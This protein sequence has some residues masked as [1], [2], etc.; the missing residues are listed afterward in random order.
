MQI[1]LISVWIKFGFIK[2]LLRTNRSKIF[3]TSAIMTHL[4]IKDKLFSLTSEKLMHVYFTPSTEYLSSHHEKKSLK[5]LKCFRYLDILVHRARGYYQNLYLCCR[6]SRY[7][8]KLLPTEDYGFRPSSTD[9][10]RATTSL[11]AL[12]T[13]YFNVYIYLLGCKPFLK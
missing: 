2:P 11:N 9:V 7:C 13:C 10:D 8:V 12:K 3:R 5:I 4:C 6:P 1:R